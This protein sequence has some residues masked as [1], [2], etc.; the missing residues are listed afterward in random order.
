M[1]AFEAG[2]GGNANDPV[3]AELMRNYCKRYGKLDVRGERFI[4][5]ALK[6]IERGVTTRE[7]ELARINRK[8]T[9]W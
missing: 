2:R 7:M 1:T 3:T 6:R 9:F 4:R 5:D 8:L